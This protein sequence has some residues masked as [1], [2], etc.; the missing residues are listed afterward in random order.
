MKTSAFSCGGLACSTAITFP[1]KT[2]K[3][4]SWIKTLTHPHITHLLFEDTGEILRQQGLE[5]QVAEE[6]GREVNEHSIL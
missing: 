6:K 3:V 1:R 4:K 5:G 2:R